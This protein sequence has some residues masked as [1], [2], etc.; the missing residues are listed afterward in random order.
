MEVH[1]AT[2]IFS[3][4]YSPAFCE[5][6]F[7]WILNSE[8]STRK[9]DSERSIKKLYAQCHVDRFRNS[10]KVLAEPIT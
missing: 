2:D 10:V 3:Q 5:M 1:V 7:Q 9:K 8:R 4:K 6:T